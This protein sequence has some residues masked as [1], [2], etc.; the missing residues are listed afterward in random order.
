[1]K[2]ARLIVMGGAI[3][4]ALG[5]GYLALNLTS[6]EPERTAE[7]SAPQIRMEEVLVAKKDI[8]LGKSLIDGSVR[9]QDWPRN[10]VGKGFITRSEQPNAV[11]E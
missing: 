10:S 4:S 6:R 7:A 8:A 3:A 2:V 11:E 5:A 1:M 9:W